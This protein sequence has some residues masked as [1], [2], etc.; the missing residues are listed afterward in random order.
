MKLKHLYSYFCIKSSVLDIVIYYGYSTFFFL[1]ELFKLTDDLVIYESFTEEC[2]L[3]LDLDLALQILSYIAKFNKKWFV[4]KK[5]LKIF[6]FHHFHQLIDY[7]KRNSYSRLKTFSV[8]NNYRIVIKCL[9]NYYM[10]ETTDFEVLFNIMKAFTC[11]VASNF[12]LL[13]NFMDF[14][15]ENCST[16]WTYKCF[17]QFHA[18]FVKQNLHR[19]E[20]EILQ[21][22]IIPSFCWIVKAGKGELFLSQNKDPSEGVVE[23]FVGC[24]RDLSRHPE[25]I[26]VLF[27]KLTIIMCDNMKFLDIYEKM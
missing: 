3:K 8:T 1:Q 20:A 13:K 7:H 16:Y 17:V 4:K 26:Q 24:I 15:A 5:K 22:I 27:L 10:N 2:F 11:P 19:A 14:V 9:I 25:E 21:Y 6:L 12:L 23:V 18:Q